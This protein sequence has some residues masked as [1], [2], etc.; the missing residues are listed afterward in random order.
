MTDLRKEYLATARRLIEIG[1]QL[2]ATPQV[3]ANDII[4]LS[5]HPHSN[6][7]SFK[8][9]NKNGNNHHQHR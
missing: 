6:F 9:R 2:G 8:I 5:T 3:M 4:L 7:E 1:Q